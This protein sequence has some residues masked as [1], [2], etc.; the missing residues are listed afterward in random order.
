MIFDLEGTLVDIGGEAVSQVF[1]SETLLEELSVEYELAIVTGASRDGL[2]FLLNNTYLGKY[3]KVQ[4]TI[5]RDE[6][7]DAKA[8]GK[9]FATLLGKGV[10]RPVVIIGDSDGDRD[11]ATAL[12]VPFVLV[13]TPQLMLGVNAMYEYIAAARNH[14]TESN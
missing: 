4:S 7:P 8:T 10:A 11:G 5:S 12:G 9:P 3:F 1:I 14:L 2:D 13:K 6:C